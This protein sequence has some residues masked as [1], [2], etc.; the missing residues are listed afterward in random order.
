MKHAVTSIVPAGIAAVLIFATPTVAHAAGVDA[1]TLIENT[2]QAS[3][4]T[5]DGTTT[6]DSNTVTL[7]VDELLDTTVASVDAGP[8]A[9][10]PG[11]EVLTFEVTN[12]GNGPEAF[13][14]TANPI[15]TGN[16]FE[17]TIDGIAV[18]TN[19]NGVYD[20]GVDEILT[21]PETT[22]E[23]DPDDSVTVFVLVTVPADAADTEQSEVELTAEAVTGSG[24]PGTTFA[25]EG[26]NGSNAVVGATGADDSANGILNVGI[27]TVELVKS[28][29]V[30]DPFGGTS[31]VPGATITYTI[32]AVVEG[33][34]SVDNLV[35]TDPFPTGTTYVTSTL[36]L[37]GSGL[38]D[39]AGDDAGEASA[40]AISVDLGTVAGGTTQ[41]IT[42][43]VTI[44]E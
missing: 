10:E 23:L 17:A 42:F 2:A 25:G 27:T 15:V 20:E 7:L 11:S 19:G 16:D 22:P 43:D 40:T 6:V 39:A 35:V 26:E 3:Y 12:T 8:I 4:E 34:G 9:T 21:G 41:N 30:S 36:A 1:G 32:S 29:V 24:A 44:E 38:T 37:D 5:A 14:L 18:D 13:T 28:A 33:S 31:P